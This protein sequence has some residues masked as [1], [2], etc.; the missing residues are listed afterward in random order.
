MEFP[1]NLESTNLS[2]EILSREIGRTAENL[3]NLYKHVQNKDTEA[4]NEGA[5]KQGAPT[6][7]Y[8]A[9]SGALCWCLQ[10]VDDQGVHRLQEEVHGVERRKPDLCDYY[11]FYVLLTSIII[12]VIITTI[13]SS[14]ID[15]FITSSIII[16]RWGIRD[17][18]CRI[19]HAFTVRAY[20]SY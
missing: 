5:P 4:Y 7:P 15:M 2:R 18:K 19:G 3:A 10:R 11:C 20:T 9:L 13:S 17:N 6:N 14:I 8:D 12:V 16:I 1:G